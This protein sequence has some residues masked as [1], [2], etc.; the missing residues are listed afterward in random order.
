MDS[1]LESLKKQLQDILG[2]FEDVETTTT[3]SKQE[4]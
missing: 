1:L 4:S 3:T 2:L